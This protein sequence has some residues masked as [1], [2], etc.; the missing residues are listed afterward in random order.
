MEKIT[1][2]KLT[3]EGTFYDYI[4]DAA[5]RVFNP[6][7]TKPVAKPV[8]NPT[9]VV[10]PPLAPQPQKSR[11]PLSNL[12]PFKKPTN[13]GRF[14]EFDLNNPQGFAGYSQICQTF[15]NGRNPNAGI[16]GNMM[17]N[18]AK[19][20]FQSTGTY[21]PP[22]LAL[23]QLAMEGG[24]STNR[25]A[26]PIR[27]NN[28][29]NIGNWDSGRRTPFANKQ[30]GIDRYYDTMAR[31]YLVGNRTAEDILQNFTNIQG[32]RYASAENYEQLLNSIVNS[33]NRMKQTMPTA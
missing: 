5:K 24:L 30:I 27:T 4:S 19:K 7:P 12:S 10:K 9:A 15:I 31:S 26:I 16:T 23:A 8:I 29:Y 1:K 6:T 21:V 3:L 25:N 17:A 14:A 28:P 2:K 20:T 11:I 13:S 33:I 18:S 32:K 22:E